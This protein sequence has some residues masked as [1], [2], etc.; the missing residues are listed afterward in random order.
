M[1]IILVVDDVSA[2][3]K[4]LVTL[5]RNEGHRL[6]EAADG[7]EAL[8]AIESTH[9]DLIITDVLM[10]VMDGYELVKQL[11]LTPGTNRI[12]VVFYTAHYGERDARTF[13]LS[14]GVS[15]V[16]T[17]PVAPDE[18]LLIIG[19]AL[20]GES[21]SSPPPADAPL[22]ASFDREHLRLVT[23][24]LSEKATD[25]SRA[26]ARLRALINIGLELVSERDVER[27]LQNV[28]IAARDLFAATYVTIG[29]LDQDQL[30]LQ[31]S[32]TEG[33]DTAGCLNVGDAVPGILRTV[34]TER[35]TLRGDN[36][37]GDP[38]ALQLP[39]LHPNVHAFLAAPIASPTHVYG[40]IC[41]VGNEG[42][43]FTEDDEALAIAL[44]GQVGRIYENRS[45]YAIAKNERDRAQRYLDTA[46]VILLAVDLQGQITQVNRYGSAVLGWP[47]DELLGRNWMETCLP[48]RVRDTSRTSV[49][50]VSDDASTIVESAILTRW[51]TERLIEW[52][53]TILR[54]RTGRTIGTFSSGADITDRKRVEEL[55]FAEQEHAQVTLHSIADGVISADANSRV[56]YLNAAAE[57]LTGWPQADAIGLSLLEVF[58]VVDATSRAATPDPAALA[59]RLGQ[60]VA[61]TA[62]R[63][64][65]R[66]DRS[67]V[68]IED[69]AAPIHRADRRITGAV[70]VFRDVSGERAVAHRMAHLA[71]YDVLTDL[72]NRTLLAERVQ[73]ATTAARRL[74]MRVGLLFVDLDRFKQ[75]N[76][77]LGHT[78][79][80]L[81]LQSVAARLLSCVR[82]SDTV[83]RH[84]GDEFV[85][86]LTNVEH[87]LDA[88]RLADRI[89]DAMSAP[90][91]IAGHI[92]HVTA[93]VGISIFPDDGDNVGA[94]ISAADAA[95]YHAKQNGRNVC[96]FFRSEMTD[97]RLARTRLESSLRDALARDEFILHYQPKIFLA[98]SRISGVE[99]LVRW[100]HPTRGL[101]APGEFVPAA[102]ECGLILPLG[103][104][105][106]REACQQA[107]AWQDLG[108]PTRMAVN[109][110]ALEFRSPGF[111]EHVA[112]VLAATGLD[113]Q[114]L[115][116][117]LTESVLMVD[118]ASTAGA[119]TALK[120]LGVCLAIDDFGTGYSSLSYLHL[121]PIDTLKID[122]SFM[123]V[124]SSVARDASIVDAIIGMGRSLKLAVVAEGIETAEQLALLLQLSC[125]EGQG[126]Y[127]SRPVT[128]EVL[129]QL[130]RLPHGEEPWAAESATRSSS[131]DAS[132]DM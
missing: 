5:L 24:K 27:L 83:S 105:V 103:N 121:F 23:D 96:E 94:L 125:R 57:R 56:V 26:N 81:L 66:R 86:L 106:L 15:F 123:Q 102:E 71:Q 65:I 45:L 29:I 113:P 76:D 37:G 11:R 61:L 48:A 35:R 67:E 12:P 110:S 59:M 14:S 74:R 33:T 42:R 97:R 87:P 119:L 91:E 38:A 124:M 73:Q 2:N 9:P 107:R 40:W 101:V 28:C 95:M 80:D 32:I 104:W 100:Q 58:K 1:S 114:Y 51:G 31:H 19:R 17:K 49:A 36:A 54:D 127:F 90:H 132:V 53:T 68:V 120:A 78:V 122:R 63:L 52:R 46:Q 89:I 92:V 79:G 3:R 16:L 108:F 98:T 10:P 22:T 128:G 72:A 43:T 13:A 60:T 69:S 126:Y 21:E 115:E 8:A 112:T 20:A 111:V 39:S 41:L 64:L 70:I 88:A 82:A 85:V 118:G 30:T 44:S 93:S 47:A 84:G 109:V 129:E 6:L 34:V 99:A 25:L 130:L 4:V 131:S 62:N 50:P 75:I 7:R 55:L 117:E 18:V 116:L 77:S